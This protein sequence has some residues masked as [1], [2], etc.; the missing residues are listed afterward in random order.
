MR[1]FKLRLIG[2]LMLLLSN[3]GCTPVI[4][5][6]CPAVPAYDRR[7]Q[8]QAADELARL[9]S[10]SELARYMEDYAVMR[11]QARACFARGVAGQVCHRCGFPAQ[12][13]PA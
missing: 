10:S 8:D 7:S 5:D 13:G 6:A 3:S 11:Q 2:L 4:S 1:C 12:Q 9:G